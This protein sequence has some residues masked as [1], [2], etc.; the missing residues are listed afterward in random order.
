MPSAPSANS[1]VVE[2]ASR[3]PFSAET[4]FALARAARGVRAA[5][6]AL[7][8]R[9]GARARRA[10]SSDGG[11]VVLAVGAPVGAPLGGAPRGLRAGPAVR[12]R[13]GGGAVRALAPPAPVRSRRPRRLRHDRP[14]RVQPAA[15]R[16]SGAAGDPLLIRPRLERMLGYRHELLRRDLETHARYADRPR[17]RIAVTRRQR[18]SSAARWYRS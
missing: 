17:L 8:A 7:G 3:L 11:R 4:V 15:R 10:G 14:D 6:A 13:A 1:S 18:V 12:R 9:P 5:D 16:A 2:R